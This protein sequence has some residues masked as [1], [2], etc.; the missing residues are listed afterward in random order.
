MICSDPELVDWTPD[1]SSSGQSS[2]RWTEVRCRGERLTNALNWVEWSENPV[3]VVLCEACGV[4]GCATGGYVHVARLDD[5]VLWTA[6]HVDPEDEFESHQYTP[7]EFIVRHGAVAIPVATW[8]R[9]RVRFDLPP[10]ETFPAGEPR[11]DWW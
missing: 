9:W 1:F 7:S 4:T 8:D 3:Q 10:A 11:D 2:P 6:P 5:L